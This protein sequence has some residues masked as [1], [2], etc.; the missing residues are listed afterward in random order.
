MIQALW[1]KVGR[2]YRWLSLKLAGAKVD[3]GPQSCDNFFSGYAPNFTCGNLYISEGCKIIVASHK[4]NQGKLEIGNNVYI[5][6]YSII[7]CH[8][9]IIIDDGVMIGP[10]CYICDFDH[11]ISLTDNDFSIK[12]DGIA[13][14][15]F[16]G[17]N[18]WLGAGVIILK[19][20]SIGEGAVIGAGSVVTKNVPANSIYVGNPARLMKMRD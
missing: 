9:N 16:I 4:G 20:V 19:G 7:D 2:R 5:N 14:P 12:P 10:H 6:F 1:A 18:A 3:Y 8:F 15:V 11:D 13:S 17:K